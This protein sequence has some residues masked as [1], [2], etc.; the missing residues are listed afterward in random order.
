MGTMR[1][2]VQV[3]PAK[4]VPASRLREAPSLMSGVT[5]RWSSAAASGTT[6]GDDGNCGEAG[7]HQHVQSSY[8]E[9]V[10][11]DHPPDVGAGRGRAS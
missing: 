5:G 1:G 6:E 3:S 7:D 11:V 2:E 4:L 10:F 8:F 9:S